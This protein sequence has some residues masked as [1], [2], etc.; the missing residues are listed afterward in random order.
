MVSRL[1]PGYVLPNQKV[2]KMIGM[3]NIVFGVG[4]L[5]AGL[6]FAGLVWLIPNVMDSTGGTM[7]T[8][9]S[10]KVVI[11]LKPRV[12]RI[13]ELVH[14]VFWIEVSLGMLLN[15]AMI[16]AGVGLIHLKNWARKLAI[17]VAALKLVRLLAMTLITMM[18]FIPDE[19]QKSQAEDSNSPF[20]VTTTNGA[21]KGVTVAASGSARVVAAIEMTAAAGQFVLG[22]I[23]PVVVLILLTRLPVWA[24]CVAERQPRKLAK[25][26]P[27][28]V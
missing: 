3:L 25:P 18:V 15:A 21:G 10:N 27:L 20:V 26:A 1:E 19:M 23:Y 5:L 11:G 6:G 13:D 14:I 2:P 28:D 24:A 8:V 7:T 9:S 16:V 22:S 17:W 12:P 4:L